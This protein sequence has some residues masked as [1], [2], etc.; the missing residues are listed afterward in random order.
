[1]ENDNEQ[2]IN[3]ESVRKVINE[4]KNKIEDIKNR[5]FKKVKTHELAKEPLKQ[6][7]QPDIGKIESII[8]KISE[9]Q[10]SSSELVRLRTVVMQLLSVINNN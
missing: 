5:Y 3:I 8:R 1:M 7:L 10:A 6:N 2:E 4:Q 9:K